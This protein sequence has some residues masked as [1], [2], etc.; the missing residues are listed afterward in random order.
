M[1]KTILALLAW[2]C[3]CCPLSLSARQ[4][5][6]GFC[7]QSGVTLQ[8]G[9]LKASQSSRVSYVGCT[10]QVLLTGTNIQVPVIYADDA[11]SSKSNPFVADTTTGAWF[12]YADS[13]IVDVRF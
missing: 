12:F 11:G 3:L 8:V 9:G 10:V 2:L 6:Q 5:F 4:R 7:D 13:S 1:R